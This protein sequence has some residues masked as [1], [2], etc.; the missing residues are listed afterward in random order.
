MGDTLFEDVVKMILPVKALVEEA[1]SYIEMD[2]KTVLRHR[3]TDRKRIEKLLGQLHNYAG[4]SEK[5]DHLF[6]QLCNFY[7]FI[8]PVMVSEW[9]EIHRDMYL[10]VYY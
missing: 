6:K 1:A 10:R 4:M 7:Y 5:A 2:V 8:D 9:I 3:I